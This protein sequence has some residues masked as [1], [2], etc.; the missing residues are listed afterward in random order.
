M[1]EQAP[2]VNCTY[3]YSGANC[4]LTFADELGGIWTA[5]EA[6]SLSVFGILSTVGLFISLS[7]VRKDGFQFSGDHRLVH[8]STLLSILSVV[9]CVDGNGWAATYPFWFGLLLYDI[10]GCI[11]FSIWLNVVYSWALFLCR[12]VLT[13]SQKFARAAK[14]AFRASLIFVWTLQPLAT[15]IAFV[16]HPFYIGKCMHYVFS[17]IILGV[18]MSG[19][20][21]SCFLIHR[22]LMDAQRRYGQDRTG[23]YTSKDAESVTVPP[24][25]ADPEEKKEEGMASRRRRMAVRRI[26][27]LNLILIFIEI[28]AIFAMAYSLS[29]WLDSQYGLEPPNVIPLPTP[30]GVFFEYVLDIVFALIATTMFWFF[31]P[32]RNRRRSDANAR[33]ADLD[34]SSHSQSHN[35][36]HNEV[37]SPRGQFRKASTGPMSMSL[38]GI[39]PSSKFTSQA[40]LSEPEVVQVSEEVVQV[41][42]VSSEQKN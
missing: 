41:S 12:V 21:C 11:V 8:L 23:V 9:R 17:L 37:E 24:S 19:E 32:S 3:P 14:Y 18:W 13:R 5:C 42:E 1:S 2:N 26:H 38:V 10:G 30:G 25:A 4:T 31:R 7:M 6:V 29:N 28:L 20:I 40:E 35:E 16:H 27:R 15:L 39:G 33:G 22:V 36:S 34:N